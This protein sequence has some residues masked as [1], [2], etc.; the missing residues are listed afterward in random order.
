[1]R[2]TFFQEKVTVTDGHYD[3]S[4]RERVVKNVFYNNASGG[5]EGETDCFTRFPL[6]LLMMFQKF[7]IMIPKERCGVG[8]K[9]RTFPT[10]LLIRSLFRYLFSTHHLPLFFPHNLQI[11]SSFHLFFFFFPVFST[12]SPPI[13][14][15]S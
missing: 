7:Q 10:L 13:I 15:S 11:L 8:S 2:N 9:K 1:M 12:P 14:N 4:V 6:L 5:E 3:T